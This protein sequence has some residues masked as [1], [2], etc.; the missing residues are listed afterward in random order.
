MRIFA[1]HAKAGERYK[2]ESGNLVEICANP[3]VLKETSQLVPWR[4]QKNNIFAYIIKDNGKRLQNTKSEDIWERI[5][6]KM[7]LDDGRLPVSNGENRRGP[8]RKSGG[9]SK[10]RLWRG[11]GLKHLDKMEALLAV[12]ADE[13][14]YYKTVS[15]YHLIG[16]SGTNFF[17]IFKSG[18]IGFSKK[19]E[20]SI[21]LYPFLKKDFGENEYLPHRISLPAVHTLGKWDEFMSVFRRHLKEC[22]QVLSYS[23]PKK[24]AA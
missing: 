10:E 15:N 4:D 7:V 9:T 23:R 17:A 21:G 18:F 12:I 8:R 6:E 20:G 1:E 19:P 13:G 14:F 16:N 11:W 2:T 3:R 24:V 22:K 5:P